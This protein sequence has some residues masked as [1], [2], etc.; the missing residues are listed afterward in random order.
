[1][2]IMVGGGRGEGGKPMWT[3]ILFYDIII[4]SANM[5]KGEWGRGGSKTL[6][7]KMWITK[8]CFF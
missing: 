3:I 7:H 1:M 5:E 2:L 8:P 6:I 4:K